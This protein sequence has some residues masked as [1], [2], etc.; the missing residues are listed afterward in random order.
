MELSA[1]GQTLSAV[2]FLGCIF[3]GVALSQFPFVRAMMAF[4]YIANAL[5][6]INLLSDKK[7]YSSFVHEAVYEKKIEDPDTKKYAANI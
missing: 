1:A 3:N 2:K 7:D 6:V 4:K 5:E